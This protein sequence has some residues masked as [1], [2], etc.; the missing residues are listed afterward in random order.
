MGQVVAQHSPVHAQEKARA[1]LEETIGRYR[2]VRYAE[3]VKSGSHFNSN[4]MV[5]KST[6]LFLNYKRF[7]RKVKNPVAGFYM[8]AY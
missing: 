7:A 3:W 4:E 1:D 6:F 2:Q 8:N 5:F